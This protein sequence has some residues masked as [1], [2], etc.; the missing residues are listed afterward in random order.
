MRPILEERGV[1]VKGMKVDDLRE[2]L[3]T[4]PDFTIHKTILE[5]YIE[6]RGHICL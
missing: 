4:Y 2:K 6:Q 3:K 5:N 1:D